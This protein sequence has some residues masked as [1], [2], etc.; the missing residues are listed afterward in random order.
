MRNVLQT[1]FCFFLFAV[2]LHAQSEWGGSVVVRGML[3]TSSKI[4]PNP[5][6]PSFDL[7]TLTT[8]FTSVLGAGLEFRV[9]PLGERWY[10]YLDVEYISQVKTEL[11]FNGVRRVTVDEGYHIIPLEAG[12]QLYIPLGSETWRLS[13]GGGLGAYYTERVWN[14]AGA[15]SEPAGNRYGFGIHVGVNAEYAVAPRIA[16]AVGLKFRDPEVDV[17]NKFTLDSIQYGNDVIT[18]PKGEVPSRINVDGMTISAGLRI[19]VF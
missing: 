3:T 10:L 18:L 1:A 13:M 19:E 9:Q 14:I 12:G 5:D 2:T 16:V 6:S 17:R 4:Y 7:R 8:P 15:S 11:R